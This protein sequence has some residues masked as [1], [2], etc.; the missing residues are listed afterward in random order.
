MQKWKPK[1]NVCKVD[2][3][4][5]ID[6]CNDGKHYQT[7]MNNGIQFH[8]KLQ[9]PDHYMARAILQDQIIHPCRFAQTKT[10]WYSSDAQTL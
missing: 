2:W 10:S 3:F 6:N 1:S 4:A 9:P 8:I 5:N 7:N